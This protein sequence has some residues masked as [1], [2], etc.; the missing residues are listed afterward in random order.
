TQREVA[1][2]LVLD[3]VA[4]RAVARDSDELADSRQFSQGTPF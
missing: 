4:E 1:N 3:E 2:L